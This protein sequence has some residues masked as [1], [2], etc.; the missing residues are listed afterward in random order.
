MSASRIRFFHEVS[1]TLKS[2][3]NLLCLLLCGGS[4]KEVKVNLEP[5]VDAGVNSMVLV[6]YLLRRQSLLSGLV[7]GSCSI[8]V[9]AT[10]KQHIPTP[11][12]AI[13][14]RHGGTGSGK[15]E[16]VKRE[17]KKEGI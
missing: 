10:D 12:A 11:Q 1:H 2:Q 8:L 17:R 16:N 9:C 4:P 6:T 13:P 15:K 14:G 7:L 5:S 3:M